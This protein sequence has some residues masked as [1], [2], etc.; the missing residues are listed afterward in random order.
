[1]LALA[2]AIHGARAGDRLTVSEAELT[3][4]L[5][6]LPADLRHDDVDVPFAI[7]DEIRDHVDELLAGIFAP[8]E[9]ARRLLLD[10]FSPTDLNITYSGFNT[11]TAREV[12]RIRYANCLGYT[13]LYIGM[14]RYAGLDSYYVEVRDLD[15]VKLLA[16]GKAVLVRGHICAG[17]DIN[18]QFE[19]YDF[20]SDVPKKYKRWRRIGDREAIAAF[21]NNRGVEAMFDDDGYRAEGRDEAVRYFQLALV[22][23]PSYGP[24]LNNLASV[25]MIE[26]DYQGA[27]HIYQSIDADGRSRAT[28]LANIGTSYLLERQPDRALDYYRR[29]LRESDKDPF[30]LEKIGVAEETLGQLSQAIDAFERAAAYHGRFARPHVALGRIYV[31][32]GDRRRAAREFR[33]ALE[34][35]DRN[36]EARQ[37]LATIA[38]ATGVS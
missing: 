21:M 26:Q 3:R 30:I 7:D 33:L 22:M 14:T 29:A 19:L 11:K 6:A 12:F 16:A 38:A 4:D 23:Q 37:G 36:E 10:L 35:D 13:N 34:I 17:I 5:A 24:A 18:A 9:R 15:D 2:A 28:V 27:R 8:R 20:A 31:R 32:L 1:M 25:Y